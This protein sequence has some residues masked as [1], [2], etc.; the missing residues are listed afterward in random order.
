MVSSGGGDP[1]WLSSGTAST[2]PIAVRAAGRLLGDLRLPVLARVVVRL[3]F[4]GGR[5]LALVGRFV[6]VRRLALVR[7]FAAVRRLAAVRVFR[8]EREV[9]ARFLRFAI[10]RLLFQISTLSKNSPRKRGTHSAG[11]WMSNPCH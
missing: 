8:D 10:G 9:A 1:P 4:T 6:A 5:R 11:T 3:R 7:R 2:G